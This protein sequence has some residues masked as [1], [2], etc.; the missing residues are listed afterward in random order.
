M[1]REE[2]LY[3]MRPAEIIELAEKLGVKVNHTGNHLKESR[4]KAHKKIMLAEDRLNGTAPA[5]TVPEK[6]EEKEVITPAP[7]EVPAP[8]EKEKKERKPRQKKEKIDVF[9]IVSGVLD[10]MP[11]VT[12]KECGNCITV[13]RDNK[14]YLEVWRR[15]VKIRLYIPE[16]LFEAKKDDITDYTE[17]VTRVDY[18]GKYNISVY[19]PAENIEKV[20]TVLMGA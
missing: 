14:K 10:T 5:E 3:A 20:L 16:E 11:N 13:K 15:A 9:G 7:A 2:K 18:N 8:A 19:V 17:N 4:E 12:Y 6:E 1:T